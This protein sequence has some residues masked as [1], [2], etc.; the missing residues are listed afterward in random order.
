MK[1]GAFFKSED[2]GKSRREINAEI[3]EVNSEIR[4][5]RNNNLTTEDQ[6]WHLRRLREARDAT[7]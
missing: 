1:L 3:R 2:H 5:R 7:Q 6:E 4:K